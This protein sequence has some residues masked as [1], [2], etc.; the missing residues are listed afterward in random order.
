MRELDMTQD[1]IALLLLN[2]PT[3][4]NKKTIS[5]LFTVHHKRKDFN[6]RLEWILFMIVMASDREQVWGGIKQY[7]YINTTFFKAKRA[8]KDVYLAIKRLHH[9]SRTAAYLCFRRNV[10][11]GSLIAAV[12]EAENPGDYLLFFQ[13][14]HFKFLFL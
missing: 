14:S 10:K 8:T 1:L 13:N 9:G 5:R 6:R 7:V 4:D 3:W 2:N 11:N 12:Q